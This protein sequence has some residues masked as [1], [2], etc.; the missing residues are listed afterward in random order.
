MK[1]SFNASN[2]LLGL[3][4]AAVN[5]LVNFSIE[6]SVIF[7]PLY[8]SDMGASN[9]E[10][11][12]IAAGY[13]TAFFLSSFF[14]GR[15]S[16]MRGRVAFI[17]AGLGLSAV[18]YLLQVFAS[19]P[20][21]LLLSRAI[22]GFCLGACSSAL[23]A[24]VY[25][26]EGRVGRFSSYGSLGWLFGAVV[27][28]ILRD[29]QALFVASAAASAVA[30][31]LSL[32]LKEQGVGRIRVAAFPTA[33]IRAN[34]KVYLPFFLRQLGAQ[35]VWAIF[36]IF[37]AGIGAS[38]AWIAVL[39]GINMAGQFVAM[40][41]VDRFNGAVMLKVGLVASALVFAAYGMSSHYLQL[42]PVQALLSVAWSCLF[43][44]AMTYLLGENV[45]RGTAAGLLYST[46]YLSTGLGPFLGGAVSQLW[47]F[48]ALMYTSSALAI[49]GLLS[50]RGLQAPSRPP[51]TPPLPGPGE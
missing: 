13:G 27:A 45:E 43:V 42:L 50:S 7:L 15:Q 16:D 17:R 3:R 28:G 29:Y 8:A 38:K 6:A 44:G 22:V 5:F 41:F 49:A 2:G 37:L 51:V 10:V 39:S 46:T 47:G 26:A 25:E 18:A 33:V 23:M 32:T 12:F 30:F 9:L 31:G 20:M 21:L 14:F 11:G 40:R 34:V 24:Y 19:S 35:A 4:L 36:P 48:G 1:Q